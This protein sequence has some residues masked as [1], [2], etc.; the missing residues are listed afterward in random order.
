MNASTTPL[1]LVSVSVSASVSVPVPVPVSERVYAC[2]FLWLCVRE[3]ICASCREVQGY[4]RNLGISPCEEAE[5]GL[6]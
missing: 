1:C 2:L 6:L 4:E 5:P 3:S